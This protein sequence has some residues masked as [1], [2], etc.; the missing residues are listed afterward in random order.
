VTFS[1]SKT[2]NLSISATAFI[3]RLNFKGGKTMSQNLILKKYLPTLAITAATVLTQSSIAHT[4][5]ADT[6]T[7]AM[8]NCH[9]FKNAYI[10]GEGGYSISRKA[11]FKV[12]GNQAGWDSPNQDYSNRIDNSSVYGFGAGYAFNKIFR[13][14]INFRQRS[15]FE[16]S[17]FF[18]LPIPGS[19]YI[20]THNMQNKAV[21]I[22]G[23]VDTAG[24]GFG[25][26]CFN[27]FAGLGLGV[28][29]NKI[30][31]AVTTQFPAAGGLSPGAFAPIVPHTKSSFTWHGTL[32][33]GMK[34]CQK[35]HVDLGYRY[36][37]MGTFE[38]GAS[39]PDFAGTLAPLRA[40]R[41][42][43]HE[44]YLGVRVPIG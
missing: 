8:S 24:F 31:D 37:D 26:D 20:R 27:P 44:I 23:Y 35:F 1:S 25:T 33:V 36:V 7:Q 6:S 28:A 3:G 21:T 4:P 13:A 15:N 32:G 41:V 18:A 40:K 34:V 22:D 12:E 16:Y 43:T 38:T 30:K 9:K 42:S 17:K 10:R 29:W 2:N 14:D 19:N 11:K 5:A 39:A